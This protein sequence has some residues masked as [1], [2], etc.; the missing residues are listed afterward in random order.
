LV[1]LAIA[2]ERVKHADQD[3]RKF[4]RS[5][6]SDMISDLLYVFMVSIAYLLGLY[7]IIN[8]LLNFLDA[9]GFLLYNYTLEFYML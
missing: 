3:V 6:S 5:P 1:V 9:K 4:L 8:Y 7:L 2:Q